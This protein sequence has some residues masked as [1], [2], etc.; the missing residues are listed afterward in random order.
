MFWK[1]TRNWPTLSEAT[2][3]DTSARDRE[4]FTTARENMP[5]R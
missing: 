1:I 2:A 3:P 5:S 4:L